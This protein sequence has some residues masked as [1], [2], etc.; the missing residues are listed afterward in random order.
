[1]DPESKQLLQENLEL[2]REN[3]RMLHSV[4][5]VQKRQAFMRIVYWLIIIGIGIYS[6]YLLQPYIAQMQSFIKSTGTTLDQ[7]KNILPQN[8]PR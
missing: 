2:A 7:F 1:M 4:R 3:N 8:T 6:F 5:G